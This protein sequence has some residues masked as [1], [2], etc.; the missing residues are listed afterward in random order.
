MATSTMPSRRTVPLA[1][2]VPRPV[3]DASV[4]IGDRVAALVRDGATLQL[5]IG[6]VPDAVLAAL[7]ARTDLRVWSE[8][9][10]D[11][12]LALDKVGALDR[13]HPVVASFAFGSAPFRH[14][15]PF[16]DFPA[17]SH[18]PDSTG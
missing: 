11:G 10:S 5:G 8:M 15:E 13:D 4:V 6:A 14:P 9:F 7:V 3:H 1:S 17:T 16:W 12:V 2:P 18:A